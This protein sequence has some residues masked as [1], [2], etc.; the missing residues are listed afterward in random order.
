MKTKYLL[1][2]IAS[3]FALAGCNQEGTTEVVQPPNYTGQYQS[4]PYETPQSEDPLVILLLAQQGNKLSGTG[5]W[6]GIT[7]N[8]D[9]TLIERHMLVTFVLKGTNVGDINGTIDSWIGSD[10]SLA[11][12]YQLWNSSALFTGAIRFKHVKL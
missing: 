11:G 9:G 12:G 2:I 3:V 1:P 6:N 8:F 7:F 10:K 4:V 5:S